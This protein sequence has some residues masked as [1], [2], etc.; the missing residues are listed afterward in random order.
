MSGAQPLFI[1]TGAFYARFDG[2]DQHHETAV[3]VFDGIREGDFPYRPL[4]TSR[5][6]IS[7]LA[8]LLLYRVSHEAAV[9]ALA[10]IRRSESFNILPVDAQV[11]AATC[12]QLEMYNDQEISFVDHT[13][14]V[15]A[16]EYDVDSVFC[17]D[18]DF[19]TLGLTCV[20][21]DVDLRIL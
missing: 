8:T 6:V 9:E 10:T 17:F 18:G 7:E 21:A 3:R 4:Y 11:F 14:G 16:A 5:Y 13:T 20:P 1:D 15:L 2:D 12:E 19:A